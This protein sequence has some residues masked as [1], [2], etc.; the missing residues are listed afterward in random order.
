M[1]RRNLQDVLGIQTVRRMKSSKAKLGLHDFNSLL[2]V[3]YGVGFR[4]NY[5][6][7]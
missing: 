5:I 6:S 3:L 2:L 1:L 7:I 4:F